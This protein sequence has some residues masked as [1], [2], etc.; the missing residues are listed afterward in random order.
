MRKILLILAVFMPQPVKLFL[1]RRI[2]KWRIGRNVRIGFSYLSVQSATIGDGVRIAHFNI[3]KDIRELTL[4]E[5][6][7]IRNFNEFFG[8][9]G[10]NKSFPSRL[11]IGDGAQIMSHHFFDVG[12]EVIVGARTTIGGRDSHV[13]SHTATMF[14]GRRQVR[15]T[16]AS[17]GE[18]VYTGA[19]V[20]LVSCTIPD[21]AMVGAGSVVTKQFPAEEQRL[22]IAGNPATIKKRYDS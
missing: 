21:R 11:T 12:G 13:W 3:F 14:E 8:Y 16:L 20:T 4:G 6:V 7:Y 9:M 22:L 18:D 19:R 2:F 5:N 1:Y 17:I 10:E 15:P